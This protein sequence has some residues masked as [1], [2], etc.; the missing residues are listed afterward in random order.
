MCRGGE[1]HIGKLLKLGLV[2]KK[3]ECGTMPQEKGSDAS[4][5]A[6]GVGSVSSLCGIAIS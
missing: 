6:F 3:Q 5:C 4:S 1:V 2:P